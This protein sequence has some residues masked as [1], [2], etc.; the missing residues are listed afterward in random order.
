MTR[1]RLLACLVPAALAVPACDIGISAGG[2]E[3]TFDRDLTVSGPLE[4]EVTSGSGDIQIRTGAD[5]AVH[6]HGRMR[7]SSGPWASFS[8]T[9]PEER[10]HELEQHPPIEQTGS[11]IQVGPK[12]WD[13]GWH[14]VSIS[15]DIT[16]PANTRVTA[17]SG[18]GDLEVADIAGPLD[19]STGSGDIR[20]GHVKDAVTAHTGSGDISVDAAAS[21]RASTGSGNVVVAGVRGDL[22]ARSGS[23]DITATQQGKGSVEV[24]T[25]SGN[26]DLSG[27][28]GPLHVRA[29]SGDINVQGAPAADWDVSASSGSVHVRLPAKGGVD[30]DLRSNSGHI[31]TPVPITVTGSQSK[32]E[33]RGQLRGGGPRVQVSTS[34]GGIVIQ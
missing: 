6:V 23:G 22:D 12:R 26:I 18:S 24:S 27:A 29:S 11:R 1:A 17:R 21:A 2:R 34:S 30:L 14:N 28:T 4:L 25:G 9:S 20:V 3:S 15:Y 16:V 7:T 19:V 13:D 31:E 10:I 33:L 5:G 32:R 8:G